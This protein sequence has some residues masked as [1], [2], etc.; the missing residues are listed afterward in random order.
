MCVWNSELQL[1]AAI[2]QS[3]GEGQQGIVVG[4]ELARGFD[5]HG[6]RDT[7]AHG[8]APTTKRL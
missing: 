3:A 1:P 2:G 4:L 8:L 5:G 7:T 6:N